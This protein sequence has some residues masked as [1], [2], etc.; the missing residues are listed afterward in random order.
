MRGFSEPVADLI[1]PFNDSQ[2]RANTSLYM[3]ILA[4][5]LNEYTSKNYREFWTST[6][7]RLSI[8]EAITMPKLFY[9]SLTLNNSIIVVKLPTITF[10]I[11]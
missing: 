8:I 11:A 7:C 2:T 1:R 6:L 10:L 3:G 4:P 5:T 9:K